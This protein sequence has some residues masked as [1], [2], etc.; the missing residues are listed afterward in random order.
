MLGE[1]LLD[2]GDTGEIVRQPLAPRGAALEDESRVEG[3][4]AGVDPCPQGLTTGSPERRLQLAAILQR[5]HP[6]ANVAEHRLDLVE[7]A[8]A[9]NAVEALAVV[10][11][12]PPDIPDVVLPG[13]EQGFV[14]IAL[15]EFGIADERDHPSR[16]RVART[17]SL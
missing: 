16:S 11:D 6:P 17:E 3:I 5:H 7:Q 13:L 2:T 8:V 14:H 10:V 12:H 4:W 1:Q 9:D 15:V